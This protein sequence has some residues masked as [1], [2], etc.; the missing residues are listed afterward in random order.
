MT[1]LTTKMNSNKVS[2]DVTADI[3][4]VIKSESD[5]RHH[6]KHDHYH[7]NDSKIHNHNGHTNSL[8][9]NERLKVR[10]T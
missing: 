6:S 8:T 1:E 9:F 3:R 7:G 4:A 2:H 10:V 5:L